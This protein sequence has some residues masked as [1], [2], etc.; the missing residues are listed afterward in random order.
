MKIF[1]V[2]SA[3]LMPF[4][5][6]NTIVNGYKDLRFGMTIEQAK[7]TKL[8]EDQW[9]LPADDDWR[10]VVRG[11]WV[12]DKFRFDDGYAVARLRFIGGQLKSIELKMP[13]YPK[14]PAE[15]LLHVLEEKYGK[16]I[17]VEQRDLIEEDILQGKI[18]KRRK[19]ES[20]LLDTYQ[21]AKGTVSLT[22]LT[23]NGIPQPAEIIYSAPEL[24]LLEKKLEDR[25]QRR[26]LLRDL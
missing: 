16:T 20:A 2:L 11:Y 24:L 22:L 9:H 8:C 26:T 25:P 19:N 14:Y 5:V 13:E 12:C 1:A 21:F 15:L 23:Y 17:E 4:V 3:F 6:P 18:R 7:E 10:R